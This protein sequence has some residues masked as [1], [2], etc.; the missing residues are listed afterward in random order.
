MGSS[1]PW[2][3]LISRMVQV[4]INLSLGNDGNFYGATR[5]KLSR[6]Y[7]I[8]KTTS[9]GVLTNMSYLTD[10]IDG[11]NPENN[12]TEDN[13]GNFYGTTWQFD[14]GVDPSGRRFYGTG[15][16]LAPSGELTTLVSFRGTNGAYPRGL[17]FASDGNLYGTTSEGG[18]TGL[19]GSGTVFKMTPS[20]A[21]TRLISF[22]GGINGSF[23]H[24]AVIQGKDGN[25][26]GTT[27]NRVF[28]MTP[29]AA[30]TILA[31]FQGTNGAACF[32]ELVEGNDGNFYG[33]TRDGGATKNFGT[34]FKITTTGTLTTLLSFNS[35]NGA[36][37]YAALVQGSDGDF[38][39]TTSEGGS[40][41]VGT[42][43]KITSQGALTTLVSFAT[44]NGATP[45]DGL[46]EWSDGNFYGT[47]SGGGLDNVGTIFKMTQS[48]FLTTLVH[49][50]RSTGRLP[51]SGLFHSRDG[52]LYGTTSSGGSAGG[53][54]I[55]RLFP[56]L[57]F[58]QSNNQLVLSWATNW[59]GTTLQTSSNA[60]SPMN[61][62]DSTNSAIVLDGRLTVTNP[63]SGTNRFYRL[64]QME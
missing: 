38:Y 37:P 2:F 21:L 53:G 47:T 63:I 11:D 12:L 40:N 1:Q 24:A 54:N 28:R 64:K 14:G 50:N 32:A 7:P 60:N 58:R 34:I 27:Q 43:F 35:T 57:H 30:L 22:N 49:L 41:R 9:A 23:P 31:S 59:L 15:F 5:F 29:A 10:G 13:E 19:S 8:F 17:I 52:N 39:G 62:I 6:G 51:R 25:F 26:Y 48:G 4:G 33:T 36:K 45:L 55:F 3:R 42:V 44:N 46:V 18:Q 61:W 16:K 20:G 56:K